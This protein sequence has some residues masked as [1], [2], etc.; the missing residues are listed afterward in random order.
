MPE[1]QSDIEMS[2]LSLLPL[3]IYRRS[4]GWWCEYN[5]CS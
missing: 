1:Y 4:C 5:G 3:L 2:S